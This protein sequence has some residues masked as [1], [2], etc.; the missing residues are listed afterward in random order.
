M[1]RRVDT[2]NQAK[3]MLHVINL[4]SVIFDISVKE[5]IWMC[6]DSDE[7]TNRKSGKKKKKTFTRYQASLNIF[8]I[9][10]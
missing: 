3:G 4:L 9:C 5:Y 6:T 7:L 1:L 8:S 10:S 2:I